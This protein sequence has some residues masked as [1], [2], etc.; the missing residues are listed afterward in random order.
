M[1]AAVRLPLRGDGLDGVGR[2]KGWKVSVL[3]RSAAVQ[4][5]SRELLATADRRL[6]P[7]PES[8]HD[9][10]SFNVVLAYRRLSC[11]I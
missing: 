9:S 7:L 3:A 11:H 8:G 1:N 5:K 6:R 2:M 10:K 4:A